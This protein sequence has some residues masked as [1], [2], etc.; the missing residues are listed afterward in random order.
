MNFDAVFQESFL[1]G[2]ETFTVI[3]EA[4]RLLGS[5]VAFIF[6]FSK[7]RDDHTE[8]GAGTS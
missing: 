1:E 2:A 4:R 5:N 7:R 8:R 3:V 6:P